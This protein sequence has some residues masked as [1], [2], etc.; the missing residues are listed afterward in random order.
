MT[1]T[2]GAPEDVNL[3]TLT[4]VAL[5]RESVQIAPAAIGWM[6]E[7]HSQFQHYVD[8]H[9]DMF[10]YGITSGAGPDAKRVYTPEQS[11]E[12]RRQ[13]LPWL[14]LSFGW[15]YLPEYVS[16]ATVFAMLPMMVAGTTSTHPER[17]CAVAAML[18]GELPRLPARGLVAAGELMPNFILRGANLYY[19][20]FSVG[21]GNGS[22]M[23]NAMS[24]LVAIFARRWLA[25]VERMF[26]L[27]VEAFRAP[28]DAYHPALKELW[29]DRFE[30]QAIDALGE[31]LAGADSDRRPFQGPVSYRILPR[32]LGQA[33]RAIGT[34][35]EVATISLREVASN[36][37]FILAGSEEPEGRVV[38]TGGYHNATAAPA[39][40]AVTGTWADL[41]AIAQRHI[42]KLHK[43]EV[44]LLPGPAA[45]AGHRL[46]HRLLDDVSGVRPQPGHRGDSAHGPADA[47]ERRRECRPRSRTTS[48]SPAPIA[49]GMH[50]AVAERFGEVLAVLGA[51]CSQ[52]LHVTDRTPAPPLVP[53]LE[54]I[55][56][57]FPPVQSR[58]PLGEDAQRLTDAISTTI[59]APDQPPRWT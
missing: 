50:D 19:K 45:A 56:E 44:S 10:I 46:H 33:R 23:S 38:S 26:A 14:K 40:D 43:G 8:A 53:L 16:R 47:L 58:R 37:T 6:A 59:H 28:L 15:G 17:A 54:F 34:L 2:I 4:R 49:F 9:R 48:R 25:L 41:A 30:A 27:S 51:V 11:A 29:G 5:E 52:A 35:E 3:A 57:H 55:R 18:D 42:V 13:G 12:W 36:P 1:V 39:I 21:S 24:G 32:V 7:T 31:L 20:G 22:Q